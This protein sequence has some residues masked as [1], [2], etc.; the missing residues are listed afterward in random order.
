MRETPRRGAGWVSLPLLLALGACAPEPSLDHRGPPCLPS[1]RLCVTNGECMPIAQ[2]M[3]SR[4]RPT[5]VSIRQVSSENLQLP[6]CTRG[7]V[8]VLPSADL[9]TTVMPTPP[10]SEIVLKAPHGA[11]LGAGPR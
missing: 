10:G 6:G 9:L 11:P 1:D 7:Q 4:L 2:V 5:S 8:Q 3:D